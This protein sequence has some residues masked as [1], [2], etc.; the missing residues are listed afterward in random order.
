MKKSELKTGMVVTMA[1]GEVY[2]VYKD[3]IIPGSE[4]IKDIMVNTN[5]SGWID[6][7]GYDENLDLTI[8]EDGYI[9]VPD[10]EFDI[11][12]VVIPTSLY[13]ILDPNSTYANRQEVVLYE[14]Y[15]PESDFEVVWGILSPD[16]ISGA[17]QAGLYTMNDFDIVYS[18]KDDTYAFDIETVYEM[19]QSEQKKYLKNILNQFTAW[20]ENN[21]YETGYRLDYYQAFSPF[22]ESSSIPELYAKFK[23]LVEGFCNTVPEMDK[24]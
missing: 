1:D 13:H 19:S 6:L 2:T 11:V 22:A 21:N 15:D 5:K 7:D 3:T 4:E 16:D 24:K 18:K 17:A 9:T 8:N 20:M 14:K 12:R 23:L 10:E